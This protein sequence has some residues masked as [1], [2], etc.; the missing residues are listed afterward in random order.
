MT[1]R[2]DEL[3]R[4]SGSAGEKG[5]PG[6]QGPKGDT[7]PQ[8]EKGDTGT[9]GP[10]GDK[11]DTGDK[12]SVDISFGSQQVVTSSTGLNAQSTASSSTTITFST[13]QK[14]ISI[15]GVQTNHW[16]YTAYS[17]TATLSSD[18]MSATIRVYSANPTTTNRTA[19]CDVTVHYVT[20]KA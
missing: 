14:Q 1:A 19:S 3:Y 6:P 7:G 11:G 18:G 20:I 10:K 4:K 2:F 13:K 15:T 5:D 12:G 9:Q 16:Y 17:C 8:G